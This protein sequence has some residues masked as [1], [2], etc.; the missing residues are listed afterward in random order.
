[1]F[2]MAQAHLMHRY[3]SLVQRIVLLHDCAVGQYVGLAGQYGMERSVRSFCSDPSE[4]L[5]FKFLFVIMC[6]CVRVCTY[7]YRCTYRP[8]A[9]DTLNL[10]IVAMST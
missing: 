8:E 6:Q 5:L 4:G 7:K 10:V 3:A 1:M 9:S 2:G